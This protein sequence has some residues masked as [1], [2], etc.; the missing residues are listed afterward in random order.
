M[1]SLPF[2]VA[3]L[4]SKHNLECLTSKICSNTFSVISDRMSVEKKIKINNFHLNIYS[5]SEVYFYII[6]MQ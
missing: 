6:Q 3:V 1:A 4:L 2:I 5:T